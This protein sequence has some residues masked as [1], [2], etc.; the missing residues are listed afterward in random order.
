MNKQVSVRRAD[1]FTLCLC[2]LILVLFSLNPG[3]ADEDDF[4]FVVLG[5]NR[6]G[7]GDRIKQPPE[8]Y[9]N[10]EEI[11]RLAP[12]FVVNTG[13]M[14][15]G[16]TDDETHA[17]DMWAE[18]EKAS[19]TLEPPLYRCFGNHDV[20]DAMS[21][22]V[23]EDLYKEMY[24]E[25]YYSYTYK[26]AYFAVLCS[27]L[28]GPDEIDYITGAQMA[29]FKADLE[30][31]KDYR[32][33]F[34]VLHKPLW[35]DEKKD[36]HWMRDV[37]PLL[38]QNDI[39][40]V[41][42]GHAHKY[43]KARTRDGIQY[44][45]S[46]GGG[47][48][49]RKDRTPAQGWFH[50]YI[51]VTVKD[52]D[53]KVAV[54]RTGNVL[55]ENVVT[56]ESESLSDILGARFKPAVELRD[57]PEAGGLAEWG[58]DNPLDVPL[59]VTTEWTLP[60]G[61]RW[62]ADP[63][64]DTWTVAPGESVTNRTAVHAPWEDLLPPPRYKVSVD[65]GKPIPFTY[66][67]QLD[68]GDRWFISEWQVIGPFGYAE[69]RRDPKPAGFDREY[70]PENELDFEKT[71]PG[72]DGQA[73]WVAA[74]A[75]EQGYVDIDTLFAVKDNAVAYAVS[76]VF[77]PEARDI[78][79]SMGTEDSFK[80]WV[81]DDRPYSLLTRRFIARDLDIVHARLKKGW[82]RILVKIADLRGGWGFYLRM[83]NPDGTLKFS[84]TPESV[85]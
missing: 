73:A 46:G 34:V 12:D 51:H 32:Y 55:D 18:F 5:D 48:P 53:F 54:V 30:K 75:N 4:R 38:V 11:N 20:W 9:Q 23:A 50:H 24:G 72:K 39:D 7:E 25:L 79:F 10:L 15:V 57:I 65:I 36:G 28:A 45:I 68:L 2:V 58:V 64:K 29:W 83:P 6:W 26:N 3:Y 62:T 69:N 61:S 70:P 22:R 19:S 60:E 42:A 17:R 81:N 37:H 85:P 13:D 82:N 59:S 63:R 52:G 76:Y 49:L 43:E 1:N 35:R 71:Y 74:T 21:H 78:V 16:Y 84:P 77:A 8:Y 67:A 31:H 56:Y 27:D 41:F 33:K 47:A 44:F 40:M 66:E 80:I 14:I